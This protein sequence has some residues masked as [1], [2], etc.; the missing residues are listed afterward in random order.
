MP[1]AKWHEPEVERILPHFL[2]LIKQRK[3]C[4]T[5]TGSQSAEPLPARLSTCVQ[6]TPPINPAL[7][8]PWPLSMST[9]RESKNMGLVLIK[10]VTPR[11]VAGQGR[12]YDKPS[13]EAE[14][15]GN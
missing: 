6:C 10:F 5:P 15:S 9:G 1:G 14:S 7:G 8:A 4:P 3:P 2:T 11:L 12:R 13:R